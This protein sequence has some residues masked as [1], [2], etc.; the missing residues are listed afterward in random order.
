MTEEAAGRTSL[1]DAAEIKVTVPF[2]ARWHAAEL[3][4]LNKKLDPSNPRNPAKDGEERADNEM[5]AFEWLGG[6]FDRA[7]QRFSPHFDFEKIL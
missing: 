2:S 5:K 7:E 4:Y 1:P 6:Q 3:D